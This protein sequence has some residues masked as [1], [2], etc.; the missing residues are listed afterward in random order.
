LHVEID[1]LEA[2]DLYRDPAGLGIEAVEIDR[3]IRRLQ[4]LKSRALGGFDLAC[5]CEA[6][7]HTTT[8]AWLR[9]RTRISPADAAAQT[10]V[11]RIHGEL[12]TLFAA[13]HA[14]QT[15]FEHLWHVEI[16][17]RKL[18]AEL[19][20]EIDAELTV[21]AT[22]WPAKEFGQWLRALAQSLGPD[23]KPKDETQ[24]EA[25]R[26]SLTVGFHGMTNVTGQLPPEVAEKLHAAL[27]AATRPDAAGEIR[28]KGQ[29][30]A[31]GLEDIL[32]TVLASA[33]LPVDGGERPHLSV[34]FD[35]DQ[36]DEAA[37][38]EHERQQHS[39][40][41]W[42]AL[43]D[44]QRATRIAAALADADTATDPTSGRPHYY[45]TG[46]A[47]SAA[48]RRLACDAILL[49]IFTRGDTAIDVGRATRTINAAQRRLIIARDNHCRWP[50][51][52][53]PSRWTQIHHVVH[54]K[55]GGPTDRWNL[56]LLCDHHH[57]AAHNGRWTIILHA[58]GR[59]TVRRR[60]RP[61]DPYYELRLTAPPPQQQPT[62]DHKLADAARRM[63]GRT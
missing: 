53:M 19:W 2:A 1:R 9:A 10:A 42:H 60:H 4:A 46:P 36:L 25:R 18:P 3:A 38:A 13:W 52:T 27:S 34:S 28:T 40:A 58:P 6:E 41:D 51:C 49:P 43:T 26:L 48:I 21:K 33:A 32:D 50:G 59:I 31:D 55:N 39:A 56:L 17:L 12:P 15:S 47:S 37:Q 20:A 45:W 54:W 57:H 63:A 5:G 30:L 61:D 44:A 7:S 16:N 22:A 62:L 29:R 23:P 35:L 14:G 24:R 8:K 11:A